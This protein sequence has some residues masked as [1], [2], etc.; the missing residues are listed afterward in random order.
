MRFFAVKR[1]MRPQR[2]PTIEHAAGT[3]IGVDPG[4]STPKNSKIGSIPPPIATQLP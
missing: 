4:G 3:R 1:P 2:P